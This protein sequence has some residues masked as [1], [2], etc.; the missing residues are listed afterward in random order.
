[1]S[2]KAPV[3]EHPGLLR[4]ILVPLDGSRQSTRAL[5][6]AARLPAGELVLLH[7]APD[8]LMI[9]PGL[10]PV[11]QQAESQDMRSELEALAA[12]LRSPER[13][14]VVEVRFGNAAD[15]ILDAAVDCSLIVM[16]T[17]GR[18]AAGRIL[19]GS[20]ADRVSRSST[21]PTL[22][23]RAGAET[24]PAPARL[25]VPLDGSER[26]EQALPVATNLARALS[27]PLHLVRAVGLDDVRTMIHEQRMAEQERSDPDSVEHTYDEARALTEERATSY[28]TETARPLE[29]SGLEVRTSLL[30]GTAVFEILAAVR[31]DDI[32][33]MTSHGRQGFRRW[34]LGSV[35]EKLV[36]E[37]PA[38]VLLV[39]T[40]DTADEA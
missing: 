35:A 34:M 38:P 13:S 19:F 21:A 12:P 29:E 18:G 10:S 6:L 4:S 27:L 36:R 28:L 3:G 14:V 15:E 26:A 31:P 9:F 5:E 30:Q 25:V 23:V 1:M 24:L 2:T 7:V 37:S 39:P 17:H 32:L 40:R 33:V 22:L 20:T 8:D 11:N 16:T